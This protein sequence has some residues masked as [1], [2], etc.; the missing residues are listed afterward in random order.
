MFGAA[1]RG[2]EWPE[3]VRWPGAVARSPRGPGPAHGLVRL[4]VSGG[5]L[6]AP[7]DAHKDRIR[8]DALTSMAMSGSTSGPFL[9]LES[10]G[11]GDEDRRAT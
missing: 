10:R 6:F 7:G 11:S 5:G 9:L 1:R 3:G 8:V 2:A 4:V